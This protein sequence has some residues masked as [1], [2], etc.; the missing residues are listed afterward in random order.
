MHI[1]IVATELVPFIEETPGSV[2]VA[3]LAS[4]FISLEHEV[5]VVIPLTPSVD[6]NAHSLAR[7]LTPIPMEMDDKSYNCIRYDGR[8]S[9]GVTVHFLEIEGLAFESGEPKR[10]EEFNRAAAAFLG[11]FTEPIDLCISYDSEAW[12]V[13]SL[14]RETASQKDSTVHM[15]ITPSLDNDTITFEKATAADRIVVFDQT[16]I[17]EAVSNG[18]E[19]LAGMISQDR[20]IGLQRPVDRCEPLTWEKKSSLKAAFQLGSELPVRSDVPLI[21]FAETENP[22]FAEVLKSLLRQDVQA[23]CRAR[24]SELSEL[25]ERYPDRLA[26][27]RDDGPL[28]KILAPA[29]ACVVGRDTRL[30]ALALCLGT[31]PIAGPGS[32]TGIVDLEPSCQSGSGIV[33]EEL[34]AS[35]LQ[36]GLNRFTSAFGNNH[37]FRS[38]VTR[39]PQYTVTWRDAA[40]HYLQL[41]EE[42]RPSKDE[43]TSA[44]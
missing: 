38:L 19:P 17:D 22:S 28:E 41:A 31:V 39:L 15:L 37:G 13:P 35:A 21:L 34:S 10:I 29:D 42:V 23:I 32:D 44:S 33:I 6:L 4:A 24:R 8:T 9:S 36:S 43:T 11:T 40:R 7:R 30:A 14:V 20:V 3:S 25:R 12:L 2:D 18:I 26:L 5:C 27:I 16:S 1:G